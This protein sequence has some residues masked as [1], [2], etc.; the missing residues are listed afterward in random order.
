MSPR[1]CRRLPLIVRA[2]GVVMLCCRQ[3]RVGR[4][5]R[6]WGT[7]GLAL[8]PSLLTQRVALPGRPGDP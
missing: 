5:G 2:G 8:L 4:L 7:A 1:G 6:G 3:I